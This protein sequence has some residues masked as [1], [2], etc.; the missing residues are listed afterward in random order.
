MAGRRKLS[1]GNWAAGP[2]NIFA[3][4]RLRYVQGAS[5]QYSTESKKCAAGISGNNFPAAS[6]FAGEPF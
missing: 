2:M 3:I 6:K 4:P 1:C 5:D